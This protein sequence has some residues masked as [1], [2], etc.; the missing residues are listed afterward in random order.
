[1][2]ALAA[3][4]AVSTTAPAAKVM[5]NLRKTFLAFMFLLSAA[6]TCRGVPAIGGR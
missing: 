4:A 2:S 1:M 3:G 6:N 5:P